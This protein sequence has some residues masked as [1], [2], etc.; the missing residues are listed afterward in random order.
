MAMVCSRVGQMP[1]TM[2]VKMRRL[3]RC[4]DVCAFLLTNG[5]IYQC[6]GLWLAVTARL[7]PCLQQPPSMTTPPR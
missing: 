3:C 7:A 1:E 5:G 2:V 6:N 4:Y